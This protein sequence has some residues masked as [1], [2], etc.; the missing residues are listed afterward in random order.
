MPTG[1]TYGVQA[2]TV[3][4]K[5]DGTFEP[6]T[7]GGPCM[8]IG[9]ITEDA[10]GQSVTTKQN[11]RGGI[12]RDAVRDE[13]PGDVTTELVMKQAQYDRTKTELMR[14][15]YYIDKRTH[16]NGTNRDAPLEYE[17]IRRLYYAKMSQRKDSGSTWEADEDALITLS[18]V[19]LEA[20]DIYRIR[21]GAIVFGAPV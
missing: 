12:V 3:Y 8:R 10:G 15:R 18:V 5:R 20:Y 16:C 1:K 2:S 6:Y 19:A 13:V 11:A 14:C 9:D 21:G 7:W 17:E 4:I